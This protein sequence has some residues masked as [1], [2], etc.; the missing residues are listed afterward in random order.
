MIVR[1]LE[2]VA[3]GLLEIAS[4]GTRQKAPFRRKGRSESRNSGNGRQE[5]AG[6]GECLAKQQSSQRIDRDVRRIQ[7]PGHSAFIQIG[8]PI[9][10]L[11]ACG[12]LPTA[13]ER[14]TWYRLIPPGHIATALSSA[15]TRIAR[16]RFN[17]GSSLSARA[18]FAA[19]YFADDPTVAQFEAGAVLGSLTPGGHLPH[20]RRSF[21]SLN[22][23][24]ALQKVAD[25]SDVA[26]QTSLATTAQE[27][28]GD[29]Q[30][31]QLRTPLT[32]VS[33]PTGLAPTQELGH[34]LFN[35]GI[36]GFRSI[37][38]RVP[39][40]QTLIVF[41]ENFL[42]GSSLTYRDDRGHIL[43]TVP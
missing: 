38:A 11:A 27:L 20:P 6:L 24:M 43:H 14:G 40:H 36:E 18:Q 7:G 15:H 2:I 8:W 3:H 12:A 34:A 21:V 17:G 9:V 32:N 42:P 39:Y 31:Y 22:V 10:N 13:P 5:L 25:L 37:S 35:T 26:A 23:T 29:W 19:L 16:T 33:A 30:G 4:Q 41:P 28:T 1:A